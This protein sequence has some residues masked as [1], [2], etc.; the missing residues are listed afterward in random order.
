MPMKDGTL[1]ERTGKERSTGEIT[2]YIYV[3]WCW[4]GYFCSNCKEMA[5]T[6]LFV[7]MAILACILLLIASITASIGAA[8]AFNS[9]TYNTNSRTRSAHQYLTIAAALGWSSLVT[10]I[11]I[12]I[13]AAVAGGFSTT[14]VSQA[15]LTKSNPTKADLIAAYKG[16]KELAGG[17]TTQLI[18]LVILIIVAI[19]TLVVGVL[20]VL[21]AVQLGGVSPKDA[22]SS[23]AYTMSIITAV[24]GVGGIAIMIVA[25]ISY[26]GI[27]KARQVQLKETEAFVA[28]T[29]QKLG[30]TPTQLEGA[31]VNIK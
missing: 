24:A 28:L 17:H 9:S 21:A 7:V 20:A 6:I 11:V 1:L 2:V 25:V 19:V 29:E 27:R 30:V 4:C 31:V 22:K 14:E 15:L 23:S 3:C 26:I 16:E 18:V 5:S 13:V 10:L 12:L 8:D